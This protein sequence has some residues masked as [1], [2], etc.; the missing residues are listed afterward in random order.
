MNPQLGGNDLA[1]FKDN[2]ILWTHI[3][4]V[5][6]SERNFPLPKTCTVKFLNI[7]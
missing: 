4:K 5:S 7:G 6:K 2:L 3:K 1:V